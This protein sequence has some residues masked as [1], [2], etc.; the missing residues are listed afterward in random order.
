LGAA[1]ATVTA[2]GAPTSEAVTKI[3]AALNAIIKPSSQAATLAAELGI[4]FNAQ[5]LQ[6][7]GLEGVL[8]DVTKATGGSADK[9][10]VLF[11]STEALQ[12]VNVLAVT[13]GQKFRDNLLE[14]KEASGAT[15]DAFGKMQGATSNLGAAIEVAFIRF[16]DP[17]LEQFRATKSATADLA[18]AW[19][20]A[21]KSGAFDELHDVI[22]AMLAALED[23][24]RQIAAN[25]PAALEKIDWSGITD[26]MGDLGD[27]FGDMFEGLDLST[28]EGLAKA[29]Q[30]IVDTGE[31][32]IRVTAGI[33]DG[34]TPFV[35]GLAA[36]V[37]EINSSDAATKEWA[38]ELLGM[39]KGINMVLPALGAM[40]DGL[41]AVGT[42]L[43]ALA[44]VKAASLLTELG[45]ASVATAAKLAGQAGLVGAAGAAGYAVGTV[46]NDGLS[47]VVETATGTKGATL[48]TWIYDLVNGSEDLAL[49]APTAATGLEEQ[50]EATAALTTAAET[51]APAVDGMTTAQFE[52]VVAAEQAAEASKGLATNT[53]TL[54]TATG[55][56]VNILRDANGNIVGYGD[57]LTG[58]ASKA[59]Q[60]AE[61]T[62][63]MTKETDSFRLKMEEIASNE[64]I[65]TIEAK[66]SLNIAALEADTKRVE[67][68]FESID[69]SINSTGDLLGSLFGSYLQ[70]E[71]T[72]DKW[73]I[74]DQIA[75]ENELRQQ[76][77]DLQKQ[78]AEAEISRIEAQVRQMERG[79]AAIQIDGTGLEP[80]L[81]AFMWAILKKIRVHANAEFQDYLLGMAA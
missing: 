52:A 49:T 43:Q 12:A 11:G 27:A 9:M 44:A 16:G 77:F 59:S 21:A 76:S 81:E 35:R 32:L 40:G 80:E 74:E 30:A 38:G 65:K 29:I 78:L 73:K 6:S 24:V 10:A 15:G 45:G 41:G 62:K 67:A 22:N 4:Q 33:V 17:L 75:K 18:T 63:E 7:R 46:L 42:G 68:A 72:W 57:G 70:A 2:A 55:R 13:S 19:G 61:K 60:A 37:Q 53:E 14:M 3:N 8:Q 47:A 64:R 26:S 79:D 5:A 25:L 20:D 51:A 39:A 1:I 56:V 34:L 69:N 71:S 36:V 66:I 23:S 58:I 48:G 54:S 28:P 50:A 31:T